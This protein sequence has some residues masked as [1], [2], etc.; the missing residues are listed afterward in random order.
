[1][2][3]IGY[4]TRE[5]NPTFIEHLKK[6]VGPKNVEIIEVVNNGEK[7]LTKVYNEILNQAKNDIVVLC[8]DDIKFED[9][10]WGNK[11]I[12]HF[13]K[14]NYGILGVAGTTNMPSSGMW[15]ENRR[16]MVGVVNHEHLGKKWES[17]YSTSLGNDIEEVVVVDGLF[18]AIHKQRIK[19]DF[20]E[21][22]DN[23]H[24]YDISFCFEN[25]MAGVHIGV[26]Y[27]IKI[28]HSSIGQ[29]NDAWEENKIK[30]ADKYSNNLPKSLPYNGKRKLNVLISCLSFKNFTGSELYV[31]ELAKN[32]LNENCEVTVVSD[33]N[34][35]LAK[36][37]LNLGIK[38]YHINEPPGFK[39]GDGKWGFN[40][41]KGFEVAQENKFYKVKEVNYDVIHT[42]HKPITEAICNLYPDVPKLYTIHS[43]VISL[44]EPILHPSIKKYVAI[45]PSIAD[46]I[47]N[48]FSVPS[49]DIVVIRNPIDEKRFN[50]VNVK[51]ENYVL[52][53][54]T[55]DY[56]RESA[57][58]DLSTYAKENNLELWLVGANSSIYL[59]ELL[60]ENHIKHFNATWNIE[61]FV[62]NCK[63]TAGIMLGRTTIEGWMCGKGGW[64]YNVDSKGDI[65]EK[66]F[67]DPPFDSELQENY[68]ASK[69]A[70][71]IKTEYINIL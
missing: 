43:E 29:T 9:K 11:I 8:H 7:S 10:G 56:L 32:L 42:Q 6:T 2:I 46:Y 44:E 63:E 34:G 33:I 40:T 61:K 25:Y 12:K 14:T 41:D 22:F 31:Y 55:I 70:K 23:F 16:K 15:W 28:T 65:T 27:N 24:F 48:D 39:L 47:E 13:T 69:V 50:K 5:N 19:S 51:N 36:M 17:K 30:F 35:P 20:I 38:L 67:Y 54:G 64:I 3:T 71:R 52:F 60:K 58:R 49:E 4:S 66:E 45:R 53:V 62:K 18:M 37:A 21:D 59:E 26:L 57:I 68:F 1:M